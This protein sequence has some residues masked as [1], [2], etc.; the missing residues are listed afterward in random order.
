MVDASSSRPAKP[1]DPVP[2]DAAPGG[3]VQQAP[4]WARPYLRLARWDRPVGFWLLVLPT[5]MGL[6]LARADGAYGWGDLGWLALMAVGAA[7]MR[8]AGCT[9]NDIIDREVDAKVARTA[10]RPIPA[11][12]VTVRQAALFL[13]AQLGVA[14]LAF[15]ALPGLAKL[16][17][18]GALPLAAA[19]PFMKRITAAPQAWLGLAMSWGFLVAYAA[20]AGRIDPAALVF[21]AGLWAW[22]VGYDTIYAHMD[23][24]DDELLGVGS[25]ARLFADKSRI[26]VTVLYAAA[27]LLTAA[28]VWLAPGPRP[29]TALA[30]AIVVVVLGQDLWR[31]VRGW[32]VDD[33]ASCLTAFRANTISG[34]R[35]FA[36]TAS[37][38]LLAGML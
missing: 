32:N 21:F 19:Y 9:F 28:G 23:K 8:G 37:A 30:A 29:V 4:A 22:T 15:V 38:P 31:Q 14:F 27:T 2:A 33:A 11:G 24:A 25:T 34:W 20:V 35:L 18:L 10:Q 7:A 1:A 6:A 36:A 3:W 16:V 12:A 13:A 5:F 17:A 26:V